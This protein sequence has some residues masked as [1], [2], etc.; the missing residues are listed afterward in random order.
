MRVKYLSI[1]LHLLSMQDT[2]IIPNAV[3]GT[4]MLPSPTWVL[5]ESGQLV[6]IRAYDAIQSP[7][8]LTR[9]LTAKMMAPRNAPPLFSVKRKSA[10]PV[11]EVGEDEDNLYDE[12]IDTS[13]KAGTLRNMYAVVRK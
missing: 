1:T 13:E 4:T 7:E 12:P 9:K 8:K 3:S 11:V 2:S 5:D 6:N 10:N